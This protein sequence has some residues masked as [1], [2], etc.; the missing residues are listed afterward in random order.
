MPMKDK[1]DVGKDAGIAAL[2]SVVCMLI[3]GAPA[4][5]YFYIGNVKKG[6]EWLIIGWL[7]LA[8][9]LGAYFFG[10]FLGGFIT[11]G[12]SSLC[13]LPVFIIPVI[14]DLV[15]VWDVYLEAKGE[16]PKLPMF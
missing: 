9:V 3:L 14:V 6:I 5:G 16:K 1:A 7:V 12:L 10:G 4:V 13:C 2:I 15:V 11:Y 8:V